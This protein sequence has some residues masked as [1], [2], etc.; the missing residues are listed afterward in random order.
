MF[1]KVVGRFFGQ[2]HKRAINDFGFLSSFFERIIE[3]CCDKSLIVKETTGADK[4][5]CL[6][7]SLGSLVGLLICTT[8]QM[9]MVTRTGSYLNI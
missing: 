4:S 5:N 8:K 7:K 3:S 6:R 2:E 9:I 1:G